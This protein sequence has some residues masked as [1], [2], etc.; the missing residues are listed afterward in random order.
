MSKQQSAAEFHSS[1]PLSSKP[2]AKDD[3]SSRIWYFTFNLG[4]R[5]RDVVSQLRGFESTQYRRDYLKDASSLS[6]SA[7]VDGSPDIRGFISG[8]NE[9]RQQFISRWLTHA[10]NPDIIDLQL[11]R[12]T[13]L[14]NS[15]LIAE[16]L[17]ESALPAEGGSVQ[18]SREG[19][20]IRVDTLNASGAPPGKP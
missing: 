5:E 20:R 13:G 10:S 6:F 11:T 4:A 12:I 8:A 17:D 16:F 3:P 9:K 2:A 15:K 7:S 1:Q 19:C 18:G 14:F